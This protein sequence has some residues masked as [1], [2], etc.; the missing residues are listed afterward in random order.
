MRS[1]GIY[2]SKQLL[3]IMELLLDGIRV[4]VWLYLRGEACLKNPLKILYPYSP[5]SFSGMNSVP[6]QDLPLDLAGFSSD[7]ADRV[8]DRGR[9][10]LG[11]RPRPGSR[12]GSGRA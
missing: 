10:G 9:R 7:E 11:P 6:F 3:K 2:F 12:A 1:Q 8:L 5:G 4:V